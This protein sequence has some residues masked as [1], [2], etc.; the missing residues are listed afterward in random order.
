MK[1]QTTVNDDNKT[2]ETVEKAKDVAGDVAEKAKDV[3][4]DIWDKTKEIAG[5]VADKTKAVYEEVTE[6]HKAEDGT[7]DT[8]GLFEKVADAITGD[9]KDDK[10]GKKIAD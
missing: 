6:E 3:A 1:E 7:A 10:T 9:D 5:T 2:N 8:R 4:G